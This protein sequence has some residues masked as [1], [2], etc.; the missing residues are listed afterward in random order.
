M[1][2]FNGNK[3]I[4][5]EE[6]SFCFHYWGIFLQ[7]WEV[8]WEGW[9]SPQEMGGMFT[10]PCPPNRLCTDAIGTAAGSLCAGRRTWRKQ[11][12]WASLTQVSSLAHCE[13]YRVCSG[14]GKYLFKVKKISRGSSDFETPWVGS[15]NTLAWY[16]HLKVISAL[17]VGHARCS[18][19]LTFWEKA[20][21]QVTHA[22]AWIFWI[23]DSILD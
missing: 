20:F 17:G 3:L 23:S 4:P 21:S 18:A 11:T 9:S 16:R 12:K 10:S 19:A 15:L 13:S 5:R 6:I 8:W 2:L 14:Y 7:L 1:D 22:P